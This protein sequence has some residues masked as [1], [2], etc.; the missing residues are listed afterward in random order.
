MP[1]GQ[2]DG[3][4]P[5]RYITLSARQHFNAIWSHISSTRVSSKLPTSCPYVTDLLGLP[6]SSK[7]TICSVYLLETRS[8]QPTDQQ[9]IPVSC[10]GAAGEATRSA[11]V[12][13]RRPTRA[14]SIASCHQR[15]R[16]RRR[17]TTS[18]HWKESGCGRWRT[19]RRIGFIRL[20]AIRCS[21]GGA[22]RWYRG[23]CG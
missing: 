11:S 12:T 13:G 5:D 9:K 21:E 17:L 18:S 22:V 1:T 7:P 23:S 15:R 10:D 20:P 14:G 4:T 19:R 2:T 16:S 6:G 3:R 8:F